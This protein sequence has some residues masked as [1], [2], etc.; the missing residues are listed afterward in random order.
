MNKQSFTLRSTA[1]FTL[2][3]VTLFLAISAGLIV[4]AL[5]GFGPRLRNV[6]FTQSVRATEAAIS[7]EFSASAAGSNSRSD[8]FSCVRGSDAGLTVPQISSASSKIAGGSDQC[9]INGALL[10]FEA[11]KM[12]SYP[13]VSL[14]LP[15][16]GQPSS[17]TSASDLET[18]LNC[19][20]P[21]VVSSDVEQPQKQEIRYQN[22]VS[23]TSSLRN[24]GKP[25]AF[26][27]VQNPNGTEKYQFF[28]IDGTNLD[29]Q[30]QI[31]PDNTEAFVAK[32]YTC[33]SLG[34]RTAKI[35]FTVVSTKPTVMFEECTV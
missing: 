18:I 15:A 23:S 7:K 4:V 24:D 11:D 29:G 6:R 19:Y 20:R 31:W 32:P 28:H 2:I 21:R 30:A 34:G 9:V 35:S 12:V 5:V 16:S 1:G 26:G 8:S 14:R 13:I 33:L 27:S 3:E 22:G 17:C 10:V 25:L